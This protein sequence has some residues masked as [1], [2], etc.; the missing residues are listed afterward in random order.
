MLLPV[1]SGY[2]NIFHKSIKDWITDEDLVE[3]LVVNPTDGSSQVVL[4]CYAE[5]RTLKTNTIVIDEL[6]AKPVYKY[7]IESLVYH[8]SKTSGKPDD[9][10]TLCNMVTDL[11][12]MYDCMLHKWVQKTCLM[13]LTETKQLHHVVPVKTQS[14]RKL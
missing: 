12:Y 8:F 5:Y 4:L 7:V 13:I 2:L 9:I 1:V 14:H 3:H 6:I 10:I 11:Q